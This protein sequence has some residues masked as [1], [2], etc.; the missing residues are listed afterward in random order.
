MSNESIIEVKN[1]TKMFKKFTAVDD[2]SFDVKKGEIF[3]LLGPNGAGKSTTLR[4][5]S[6][7][8]RPTKGSATIG[9]FDTV[10]NDMEVRKLI[11][12]VSEK[13]IIYNRLTAKENLWFF[14]SLFNIPKDTLNKRIDE[15]LELVQ[16]TKWKD[17][18]VGTFSTGMRQRM[19]VIR[20]LLNMP[21]VLFLDEPTLGLDPQSSVEIR[22][23]VKKL[24]QERGTTVIITTHMMVD[25]DLLCDRIAIVDHGKI[26][27]LD[28]STN[29]KKIISGGDTMIIKLEIAN[30]TPD[31]LASIKALNCADAV[32]QEN[33]TRLHI[34]VHGEDAFGN[35]ID[36]VRKQNGKISSME[37]LQPTLEDVFLH[38][39]GHEVRDSADQKIP[40]EQ[41][42]GRRF[43]GAPR[44]VR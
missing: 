4:M 40:M 44:R 17:A 3:G 39:T 14:G 26:I 12:I 5:L 23:F 19:N 36:A 1:L 31:L 30:L 28:T 11:G 37:N 13:M 18:Q 22:D 21:Q 34:I 8:S 6:T 9:G 42:R 35:I 15:L 38:I 32:T 24:N 41:A 27:A 7:L 29:L 10:K 33:A 43:G 2:I 16:L 25:A 20:A